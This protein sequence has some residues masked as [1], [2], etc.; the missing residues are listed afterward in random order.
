MGNC[1]FTKLK[2]TVDN[3]SLLMYGE[4]C[5]MSKTGNSRVKFMMRDDSSVKYRIVSGNGHFS[6]SNYQADYGKN[7]TVGSNEYAYIVSQSEDGCKI[8]FNAKYGDVGSIELRSLTIDGD[9]LNYFAD[10][11]WGM[12]GY[13][14]LI[15]NDVSK[16]VIRCDIG[17][18]N[19][20]ISFE[21]SE[22][23]ATTM[24]RNSLP[25]MQTNNGNICIGGHFRVNLAELE[26]YSNVAVHRMDGAYGDI[27]Y[28][29][30]VNC[31]RFESPAYESIRDQL[32]GSIEGF[33]DRAINVN[34]KTSGTLTLPWAKLGPTNITFE[35]IRLP[36]NPN[37]TSAAT[38]K[39]TWNSQGDITWSV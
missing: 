28:L 18:L 32:T 21:V 25:L 38:S 39:F 37:V 35:G 16:L 36:D 27:K 22:E 2:G 26:G 13:D 5:F 7:I 34:G 3:D 4:G 11:V 31:T 17:T 29:S 9:N 23:S 30:D 1:L 20:P 15:T 6:D 14:N 24:L 19:N 12:N 8:A 10:S 33:V